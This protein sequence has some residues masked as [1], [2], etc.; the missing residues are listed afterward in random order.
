MIANLTEHLPCEFGL[1]VGDHEQE[2]EKKIRGGEDEVGRMHAALLH[3]NED[4]HTVSYFFEYRR[5]HQ[6]TKTNW[7]S[8]NEEKCDLPG[9][10]ESHKSIEE[11]R[12]VD[13]R[14]VHATDQIKHE[15]KRSDNQEAPNAGNPEN[16]LGKSHFCLRRRES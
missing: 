12:M 16:Y 3:Q 14:W 15:V 4:S 13:W 8:R 10:P 11:S 5:N 1:E 7:V 6:R 2:A 9:Q